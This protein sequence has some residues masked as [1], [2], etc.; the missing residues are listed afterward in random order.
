MM[1]RM[2]RQ[3][4]DGLAAQVALIAHE[5]RHSEGNNYFHVSCCGI[6]GG[7]DQT[8]DETNLS[9]YGIQ[10]YLA[11]LWLNGTINLGYSCDATTRAQ[12]AT[13]FQGLANVYP[14]RFCDVKPPTLNLPPAPGG[15]CISAC[16]FNL[17]T[18][19]SSPIS[20]NGGLS[21]LQVT[22][23]SPSCG[24][25]VDS[26]D[27]WIFAASE[28]NSA[29]N[30]TATF[31]VTANNTG[32]SRSSTLI[33]GGL[34][35]PITQIACS[36]CTSAVSI[37]SVVSG[38]PFAS[39]VSGGSWVTI[40][41]T[42]LAGTTRQWGDGDFSGNKLPLSLDGV[43]V[44]IDGQ[45]AAVYYISPTQLNVQS[46]DDAATGPVQVQVANQQSTAT[47]T[48]NMQ[49][50]APAFFTF[51][52]KY[53]AAVHSDGTFVGPAGLFGA[54]VASRHASPGEVV[55]LFGTGFGP[56]NPPTG[57]GVVLGGAAP[58]ANPALLQIRIG[59]QP[60]SV[61]FAGLTG[62]GLYQFNVMIP[63]LPGG[64]SAVVATISNVASPSN[65]FIATHQ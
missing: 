5:V 20:G 37:T 2:Y 22:V 52:T 43:T 64:D 13:A 60:A 18:V 42:N 45:P 3:M 6:D 19:P 27:N 17:V 36:S 1:N 61:Q 62:A 56:T 54:S 4:A 41:G 55:L 34:T 7:C 58:L 40:Y 35:T 9:P 24:W 63:E 51:G 14:S 30:G 11:K 12:L 50:Y 29:G 38:A 23:S 21:S 25:T 16:T 39:A 33:A 48:G 26:P 10:Y 31:G 53:V 47:S 44:R 57:A 49:R 8:Y 15:A 28:L 59:G 32:S 65:V 46:P